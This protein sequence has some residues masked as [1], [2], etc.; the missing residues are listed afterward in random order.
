[1]PLSWL[2]PPGPALNPSSESLLWRRLSSA[3]VLSLRASVSQPV[4]AGVVTTWGKEQAGP[5]WDVEPVL[6]L[7]SASG[8]LPKPVQCPA[9][10]RVPEY[11]CP[12]PA[13][14]GRRALGASRGPLW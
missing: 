14:E 6:G 9:A 3:K 5:S 13:G 2:I 4:N 10:S 8:P 1:M 12:D 11:H 7:A